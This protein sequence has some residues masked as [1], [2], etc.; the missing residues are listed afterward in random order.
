MRRSVIIIAL[1]KHKYRRLRKYLFYRNKWKF[2]SNHLFFFLIGSPLGR[3][4]RRNIWRHRRHR[5]RTRSRYH[6]CYQHRHR[7]RIWHRHRRTRSRHRHRRTRSPHRN[8]RTRSRHRPRPLTTN[9][10]AITATKTR[11]TSEI[12]IHPARCTRSTWPRHRSKIL[13]NRHCSIS[14]GKSR[15]RTVKNTRRRRIPTS[16]KR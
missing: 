11:A 12:A 5:R 4:I 15:R 3:L 2:L 7:T 13:K 14:S 6:R 1:N 16:T 10:V 8:R 9:T